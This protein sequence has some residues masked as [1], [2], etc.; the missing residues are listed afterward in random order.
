MNR[1]LVQFKSR[2][3]FLALLFILFQVSFDQWT[4]K[5]AEDH[6]MVWS[7]DINPRQYQ[8]KRLILMQMGQDK[9]F[10]QEGSFLELGFNYVRNQGAAWG[11]LSSLEDWIRVPFF[12][13]VGILA[14][15]MLIGY[16]WQTPVDDRWTR[17]A[18]LLVL[19]GAFGNFIDRIIR[20]YV[21]DFID[22]RWS[23]PLLDW[24][25]QQFDTNYWIYA[26]PSFNWADSMITVGVI[27]LVFEVVI[28][29]N[30][31]PSA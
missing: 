23:I 9:E 22:V 20:G 10:M 11:M 21:I 4:K 29:E 28:K 8:G 7:D 17:F 27:F 5:I 18:L 3:G 6:L 13:I 30:L 1:F 24:L 16:L 12:M 15:F 25:A 2:V 31:R 26:F 19:S 14:I